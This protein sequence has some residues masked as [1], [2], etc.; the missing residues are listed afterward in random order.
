MV[1]KD[2]AGRIRLREQDM[3]VNNRAYRVRLMQQGIVGKDRTEQGGS[4]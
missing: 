1:R 4:G 2:R 3:V